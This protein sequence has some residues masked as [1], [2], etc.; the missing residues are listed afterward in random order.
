MLL[1][2]KLEFI[3]SEVDHFLFAISS[4]SVDWLRLWLCNGILVGQYLTPTIPCLSSEISK[5]ETQDPGIW[6]SKYDPH[7]QAITK[8]LRNHSLAL[9]A[10]GLA[11]L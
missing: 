8:L 9:S 1:L 2:F 5:E 4:Y 7:L 3:A 10:R 6:K 11:N